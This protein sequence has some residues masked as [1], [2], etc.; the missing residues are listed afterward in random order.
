MSYKPNGKYV[1]IKAKMKE[2]TVGG[3]VLPYKTDDLEGM[4][5]YK[6]DLYI[7]DEVVLEVGPKAEFVKKGDKIHTTKK[8]LKMLN[9]DQCQAFEI[10]REKDDAVYLAEE[11]SVLGV[12]E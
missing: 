1:L 7:S 8:G 10:E 11:D 2:K 9:Q 5:N 3:I 6:K 4:L 12:I